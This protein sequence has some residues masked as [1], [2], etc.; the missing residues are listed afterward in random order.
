LVDTTVE[1]MATECITEFDK[2]LFEF[3]KLGKFE[4]NPWSTPK[5]AAKLGVQEKDVYESLCR[6]QKLMKGK[7]YMYYKNGAIRIQ[8]E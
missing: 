6:L 4:E 5:A 7:M 2:K 1:T 3:I 8:A